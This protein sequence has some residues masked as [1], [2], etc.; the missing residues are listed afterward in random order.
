MKKFFDEMK[1]LDSSLRRLAIRALEGTGKRL[2]LIL[3]ASNPAAASRSLTEFQQVG[4]TWEGEKAIGGTTGSDYYWT[5]RPA[6][7]CEDPKID[8]GALRFLST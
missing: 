8:E 7:D 3:F 5:F 4:N 6:K 2:T 1:I